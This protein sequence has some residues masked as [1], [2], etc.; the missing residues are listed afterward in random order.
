MLPPGLPIFS[1][2][3]SHSST[4][5]RSRAAETES[6]YGEIDGRALAPDEPT[7]PA[8]PKW[9]QAQSN[10]SYKT[11]NFKDFSCLHFSF[12]QIHTLNFQ[13]NT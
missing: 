13:L 12:P 4:A 1:S 6:K 5:L 11:P 3:V 9:L 8:Q 7:L 2:A 10:S